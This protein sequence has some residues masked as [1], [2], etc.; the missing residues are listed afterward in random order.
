MPGAVRVGVVHDAS[1]TGARLDEL[2][3]GRRE[4]Q[5]LVIEGPQAA[6]GVGAEL[7]P[8]RGGAAEPDQRKHLTAGQHNANGAVKERRG[9]DGRHLMR[10]QA[11]RS[12]S[13]ADM[14]G[15]HPDGARVE[16]EE[17]RELAR[18]PERALIGV[19]DLQP[20]ALPPGRRRVRFHGVVVFLRGG[21]LLVHDEGRLPE[22][23]CQVPLRRV[24]VGHRGG[25]GGVRTGVPGGE[26]HVVRFLFVADLQRLGGLPGLLG[27][28]GDDQRHGP[29]HEGH[30][31]VLEEPDDRVGPSQEAHVA[32]VDPGCVPVVEHG[33]HSGHVPDGAVL[34]GPD[35][36]PRHRRQHQPAV[37]EFGEGDL[38]GVP[39]GAGDLVPS[40]HACTGGADG[41]RHRGVL[42]RRG[43]RAAS[44][45]SSV[46][47]ATTRLRI[48]VTL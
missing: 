31:V 19:D 41:T 17:R 11:L 27:R 16:G 33:E 48:R 36:A 23:G 26:P 42:G 37:G 34:D 3:H 43:H 39:G 40:L 46:S 13:A 25:V 1:H 47:T 20:A 35:A 30:A 12:E 18:H 15:A 8:L 21:V 4:T 9:H 29:A 28:L 14:L 6:V 44:S 22:P 5:C 32:G 2:V 7:D 45:A 38:T 10:G 24:R